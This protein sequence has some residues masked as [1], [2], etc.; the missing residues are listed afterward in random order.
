MRPV[1]IRAEGFA[2]YR[3]PVD[4]DFTDVE[5][6][7]L[8]GPTGSG[9]S[10]LIDAMVFALF[11]RVPRLGGNSVAP[12]ISVGMDAAKVAFDF[13]VDDVT[14]TAVRRADR[15]GS[16]ASVKEARLQIGEKVVADGAAEVTDEVESVLRLRFDDF[17]RTVVLP[18]GEFARFLSAGKAERQALLRS[19]LG[20]DIYQEVRT[21]ARSRA[22]VASERASIASQSLAGLA[23][24]TPE[25]AEEAESRLEALQDLDSK[26]ADEER[27]LAESEVAVDQVRGELE[28]LAGAIKRLTAIE[29][30]EDLADIDRLTGEAREAVGI[31]EAQVAKVTDEVA[32]IEDELGQML[33]LDR[34]NDLKSDFEELT[35]VEAELAG[36]DLS[37]AVSGL[38][39]A[40]KGH[41]SA[42]A[43]LSSARERLDQTR[44]SHAAHAL[45]E[46]LVEGEPCPV[47]SQTVSTVGTLETP[48]VL[49]Q[50]EAE[51]AAADSEVA[52]A[53][54]NLDKAR[55]HH[56]RLEAV[57]GQ[58]TERVKAL[59]GRVAEAPALDALAKIELRHTELTK[60]LA[61][62]RAALGDAGDGLKAAQRRLED[63]ADSARQVERRLTAAQLEVAD[64]NP[65]LSE[66]DDVVVKW[67]DLILWR[68]EKSEELNRSHGEATKALVE[69]EKTATTLRVEIVARLEKLGVEQVE[70]YS[71]RVAAAREQAR[72][73]VEQHKAA[74]AEKTRLEAEIKEAS[75]KAAVAE[76][77]AGHLRSDGFE[78][79]L[80]SG[81]IT[82]LVH[83]AN[84]ILDELTAGGYSLHS[85]ES[86]SFSIVD[87]R[88]ADELRP[89]A[90][91]SGGET[92]LVSLALAL[93]LAETL[94]AAG[95]AK[96]DTIIL[97]EGFGTLDD[98][99]LETVASIL[100]EL[101]GEG[102]TVGVITHVKEL[103]ARAPVRFE[104]SKEPDGS[105]VKDVSDD[106]DGSRVR[107][108]S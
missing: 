101:S 36:T 102:L 43:T 70:P 93:S 8:S 2:A 96:L 69:A 90:T 40:E 80:M 37:E 34:V 74:A 59:K 71:A 97:D 62:K 27:S 64:L 30:P 60:D 72:Q 103:A 84:D 11:G 38:E 88:N 56:S 4:I 29:A 6:F 51:V 107:S 23:V 28:S 55:D 100:E 21:L 35:K 26:I 82:E 58:L 5:F 1:R 108:A 76:S 91:L 106:V 12:A 48:A 105:T 83:G 85:D 3:K 50:V 86:G 98:E 42:V 57:A 18:Q 45:A 81:A 73:V 89:V 75:E 95:G 25:E 24:A 99:S 47:C 77:L 92:F 46:T 79:W 78:R 67:K 68:E 65:P 17:I 19:L 20:L 44:V 52:T 13:E 32:A 54:S 39:A 104:V 87:H 53:R 66:S 14:Y 15:T 31:A 41:E 22:E 63:L 61:G 7:S 33:S 10:S 16:G 94:S 49:E 9:K